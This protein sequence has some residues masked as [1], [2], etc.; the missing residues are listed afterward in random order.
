MDRSNYL[1]ART[2]Y[3]ISEKVG[4]SSFR[5][6]MFSI[7]PRENNSFIAWG[8]YRVSIY[9]DESEIRVVLN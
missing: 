7:D 3:H 1:A 2:C 4:G 8:K 5:D 9:D 6:G